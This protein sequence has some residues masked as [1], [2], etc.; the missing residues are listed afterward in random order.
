MDSYLDYGLALLPLLGVTIFQIVDETPTSSENLG[1]TPQDS[2]SALPPEVA[3]DE[4]TLLFLSTVQ[5]EASGRDESRGFV[6]YEGALARTTKNKMQPGYERIREQMIKDELLVP[7]NDDQLRLTRNY[8][9]DSPSAAAS[10]LAGGSKNGRTEWRDAKGRTLK[11]L[12]NLV[13]QTP[14]LPLKPN[15]PDDT[16]PLVGEPSAS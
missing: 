6:V 9:F 12:Q 11:D 1:L 8:L 3:A 16:E 4:R 2:T 13:T 14:A 7:A 10:V 5:T 15:A